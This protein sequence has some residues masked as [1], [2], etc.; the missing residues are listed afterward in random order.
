MKKKK[1]SGLL[2]LIKMQRELKPQNHRK[3]KGKVQLASLWPWPSGW[4]GEDPIRS[5]DAPAAHRLPTSASQPLWPGR[6]GT[7]GVVSCCKEATW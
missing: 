1:K 5:G 2:Q 6:A 7:G 3:E 4:Q